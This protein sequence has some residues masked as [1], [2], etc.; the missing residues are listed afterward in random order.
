MILE[1]LLSVN[2]EDRLCGCLSLSRHATSPQ[3][4]QNVLDSQIIRVCGPLL[5]DSDPMVKLAA[6]GALKNISVID[7]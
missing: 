3:V 5:V 7:A 4:R 6:V 2:S 1:Q